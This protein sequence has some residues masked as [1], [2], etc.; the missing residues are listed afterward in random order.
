MIYNNIDFEI[1]NVA[2]KGMSQH[3]FRYVVIL[4]K[5]KKMDGL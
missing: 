4:Q 3:W 5:T 1:I 2:N